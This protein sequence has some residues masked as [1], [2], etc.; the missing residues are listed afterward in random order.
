VG[1]FCSDVSTKIPQ[2]NISFYRISYFFVKRIHSLK[3]SHIWNNFSVPYTVHFR[4]S[5]FLHQVKASYGLN[6]MFLEIS[7]NDL[8]KKIQ[9]FILRLTVQKLLMKIQTKIKI[10]QI[11]SKLIILD[12]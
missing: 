4:R 2:K 11:F 6:N 7:Q 3:L 10:Q 12:H 8:F 1:Y 9:I 5:L